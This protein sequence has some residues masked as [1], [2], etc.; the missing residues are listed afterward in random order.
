MQTS[1]SAR[2]FAVVVV[3]ASAGGVLTLGRA[4]GGCSSESPVTAAAVPRAADDAAIETPRDAG[5]PDVAAPD[6]S[7]PPLV[8]TFP[9]GFLFGTAIVGFPSGHGLPNTWCGA[10]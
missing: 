9:R 2:R 7:E 10:L 8:G 6:A 5:T 1:P 4:I 3:I